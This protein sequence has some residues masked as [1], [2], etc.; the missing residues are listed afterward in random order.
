[1]RLIKTALAVAILSTLSLQCVAVPKSDSNDMSG[2][3]TK[4]EITNKQFLDIAL[5]EHS[6][7]E[8]LENRLLITFDAISKSESISKWPSMKFRPIQ[9]NYDW[10]AQGGLKLLVENPTAQEV[11]FEIKIADHLGTLGAASHQLDY[12]ISIPANS[13]KEV[14]LLF[15][16][17]AMNVKGYRGGDELQL[18]NIAEFQFYT[19]GPAQQQSIILHN[20]DFI[21]RTGDFVVTQARKNQVKG[22]I[23]TLHVLTDFEKGLGNLIE[24]HDGSQVDLINNKHGK[25]LQVAYSTQSDYPTVKF[26]AGI[27]GQAWDWSSF[28]DAAVAFDIVNPSDSGIQLF[29]R[30]DDALDKKLGGDATGAVH[31]RTGYA[32]IAPNSS[33]KYYFTLKDLEQGLDSGMRGEPPEKAFDANQVVFGWGE[34]ELDTSNI[35]SIQLYLMNPKQDAV[36]AIEKISL[37]PNVSLDTSRYI[38]LLDEFGQYMEE[39]WTE[40]INTVEELKRYGQAD[41]LLIDSAKLPADRSKYSGWK[42]G[43]KLEATGFFRTEKIDGKWSLVDPEG[44]LYFMTGLDNIRMDD[45]Y[46]VTG[47]DFADAS[48]SSKENMRP[49]QLKDISYKLDK[50]KRVVASPL[51]SQMFTWLPDYSSPLADN[52]SYTEM[53]HMGPLAH[54]EVFSFYSANLQRKYGTKNSQETL[55]IWKDVTLARMEDW[56]FT[57][58]GNWSDPM[59]RHNGKMP[60]TAHGWITGTHQKVSTGNDYWG[61]MHDPFD[62]QFRVS[63]ASMAEEIGKEVNNDPWCIGYFVDNELSWGNT[64]SDTNHYSLIVSALRSDIKQSHTKAVLANLLKGKYGTIDKFNQAWGVS[65]ESWQEFSKGFDFQG[66]YTNVIKTDLSEMLFKFA[67]KY[68]SVVS[69]EMAKKLP[70]HMF[71]GSRFADWA[72]TPEAAEAAAKYVDVMSYNLYASDLN[73]KGDWSRLAKLDK[74]SVIGEFHFGSLDSGLFHPGIMSAD[75]QFGRSESYT[76]YMQSIIENPYFVGAHWFQYMDSPVTGRAWDGENYNVGFVTVA[77][78]PYKPLVNAAKAFNESLY[79]NRFK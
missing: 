6:K 49:S 45:S 29:V 20:I 69:E 66:E 79:Q 4:I 51:R 71:L 3:A 72:I 56:G 64:V 61:P 78:V 48:G 14:E 73:S 12:A 60:Y 30:I 37:I 19:V 74:P 8:V 16:G 5:N 18:A 13:T 22:E 25:A 17:S 68:F 23:E 1:M 54:G 57:S 70:N 31:S 39:T 53:I 46:T 24:H 21:K 7:F 10:N 67:D 58:L 63:V 65:V 62:P 36:L 47:I 28:G 52:Y 15:N 27:E 41:L 55:S 43:P 40:K 2:S 75:N 77:D 44:Y 32:Q 50:R 26:S 34:K 76:K 42:H 38:G 11:N 33:G 35:V 9:G 59:Y